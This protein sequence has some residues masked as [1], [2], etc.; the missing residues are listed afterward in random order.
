MFQG[1]T[2]TDRILQEEE[3]DEEPQ[4][5]A[6]Q[7]EELA[8]EAAPNTWAE[9]ADSIGVPREN[10]V[11]DDFQIH[12]DDY[13]DD[14]I[15]QSPR[16]VNEPLDPFDQ[17]AR[18]ADELFDSFNQ[19]PRRADEPLDPFDQPARP[20]YELLDPFDQPPL[21]VDES[22][23]PAAPALP[24]PGNNDPSLLTEHIRRPDASFD[25]PEILF[26]PL[27]NNSL[28]NTLDHFS[29]RSE[30]VSSEPTL[31]S[32]ISYRDTFDEYIQPGMSIKEI[33][34]IF[35]RVLR[36]QEFVLVQEQSFI[37]FNPISIIM[38]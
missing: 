35:Q 32:N 28:G 16:R 26:S 15:I 17:P 13:Y 9:T 38:F 20:A 21:V 23:D 4:A 11:V 31:L 7:D 33:V 24:P 14:P 2:R 8:F 34:T 5:P 27:E 29:L 37:E 30:N 1:N 10:D 18:Q 22:L 12:I 6:P 19:P 36:N 3:L 25:A